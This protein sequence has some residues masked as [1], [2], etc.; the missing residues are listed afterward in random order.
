MADEQPRGRGGRR[1]G[2][3]RGQPRRGGVD[4]GGGE[5]EPQ[6]HRRDQRDLEIAAQG[7]RIRELER[8]LAAARVDIHRD[9]DRVSSSEDGDEEG[10]DTDSASNEEEDVNPWGAN[11][12]HRVHGFRP[13]RLARSQD[14]GM[15]VDIP[16]FE[17]K[18]H[19]DEF[20]DWLHIVERV[21]DVKN[22]SDEQKVKLVAIKLKKNASIWWEHVKKQRIREGKPKIASWYKMKKKLMAKFLPVHYKQEAYIE[23]HNFRQGSSM[24]VE[25]FTGEFDRLRMRCDVDEEDEQTVARYLACLRSEIA[26]VVHLQQFWSYND[27]CRLAL[28][29]ESQLKK[30]TSN[31]QFN[32]RFTGTENGKRVVGPNPVRNSGTG[33]DPNPIHNNNSNPSSSRGGVTNTKRLSGPISS[34]ITAS[35]IYDHGSSSTS[36]ALPISNSLLFFSSCAC[37]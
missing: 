33:S 6:P 20:I 31:S 25:D 9:V 2:R 4:G 18:P 21:F 5:E 11:R 26:D 7:R 12:R 19:P 35:T 23:Y 13:G 3:V 30:K 24:S 37:S 8:L 27:V 34:N 32:R 16:V 29:V 22:L 36:L 14:F 15:K 17:G 28:K 1:G 10:F